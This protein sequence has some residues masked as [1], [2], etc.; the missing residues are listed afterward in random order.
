[1][2]ETMRWPKGVVENVVNCRRQNSETRRHLPIDR[3]IEQRAAILLV[4]ADV[5]HSWNRLELIEVDRLSND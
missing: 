5:D 4:R 1:M 3:H 2:V